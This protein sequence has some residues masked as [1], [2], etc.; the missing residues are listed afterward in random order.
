MKNLTAAGS[1]DR[2]AL[3]VTAVAAIKNW[4]F[5]LVGAFLLLMLI[6][7]MATA[8]LYVLGIGSDD[9]SCIDHAC[10]EINAPTPNQ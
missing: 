7:G 2:A 1:P 8:C 9:P 10:H 6:L 3:M 5:K 4:L